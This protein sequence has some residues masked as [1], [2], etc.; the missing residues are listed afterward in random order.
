MGGAPSRAPCL[1]YRGGAD[2]GVR[3]REAVWR[4]VGPAGSRGSEGRGAVDE[5]LEVLERILANALLFPR[6]EKYRRGIRVGSRTFGKVRRLGWA[7]RDVL[8]VAGFEATWTWR[9][10]Y[11]MCEVLGLPV[12]NGRARRG[13]RG[14]PHAHALWVVLNEV[15]RA[16]K[17]AARVQRVHENDTADGEDTKAVSGVPVPRADTPAPGNAAGDAPAS[18]VGVEAVGAT[19]ISKESVRAGDVLFHRKQGKHS[20]RLPGVS[21]EKWR[22]NQRSAR[23]H[24]ARLKERGARPQRPGDVAA[25]TPFGLPTFPGSPASSAVILRATER[26]LQL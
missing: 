26:R 19:E 1:G 17:K 9:A 24:F 12:R 15:R 11:G 7:G 8:E 18:E 21:Q 13:K 16:R 10:E 4:V 20:S 6:E 23:L 5:G 22:E 14:D 2:V 3:A 25:L